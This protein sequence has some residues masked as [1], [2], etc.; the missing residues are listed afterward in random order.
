MGDLFDIEVPKPY[1]KYSGAVHIAQENKELELYRE[2]T[3]PR[4][5]L[6]QATLKAYQKRFKSLDETL[7][8]AGVDTLLTEY[9][10][11]QSDYKSLQSQHYEAIKRLEQYPDD[12]NAQREARA[13]IALVNDNAQSIYDDY[14][15]L[16]KRLAPYRD[17]IRARRLLRQRIDQH[18]AAI[19]DDEINRQN[20]ELM[21]KE[22]NAIA[23]TIVRIYNGLNLCYRKTVRQGRKPKEITI[24]VKFSRVVVTPDTIQFK[25]AVSRQGL[26]GGIINLLPRGVVAMKLIE[27]NVLAQISAAIEMPV[28]CPQKDTGRFHEGFW[29]F[30]QRNGLRDGLPTN[31]PYRDFQRRYPTHGRDKLPVPGGVKEGRFAV[32]INLVDTPHVIFTGQTGSGKTRA[33]LS[34]ITTLIT[35]HSPAD[36]QLLLVDL[37]E[38]VD[39]HD[40]AGI[41]HTIGNVIESASEAARVVASLEELRRQRMLEIKRSGARDIRGYNRNHPTYKMPHVFIIFDEYGALNSGP[42]KESATAIHQYV[43]LLGMKARAAGIHVV[44]GAQTPRS[45]HIPPGVQDNITL[46]FNARQGSLGASLAATGTGD[47]RHLEQTPGRFLCDRGGDIYPVQMPYCTDDDVNAAIA[48]AMEFEAV[49]LIALPGNDNDSI[50]SVAMKE[51]TQTDVIDIAASELDGSLNYRKVYDLAKGAYNVS[52]RQVGRLVAAIRELDQ[53]TDSNGNTY[54]LVKIG[55]GCRLERATQDDTSDVIAQTGEQI[56]EQTEKEIAA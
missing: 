38:G 35:N 55:P 20:R 27:D 34:W 22:A 33:M 51:F 56:G 45:Q 30:V 18:H 17:Q 9:E 43:A 15:A 29:L 1:S 8:K 46:K 5:I 12:E 3:D 10:T 48:A 7:Y 21:H 52:Q 24:S 13:T 14:V 41:P 25:L 39:L 36:V 44:I 53:V 50:E 6:D 32:W 19:E 16:K 42:D 28:T 11:L 40:F 4:R 23:E 47:A 54:N 49:E 2:P 37:K 26:F 31:V